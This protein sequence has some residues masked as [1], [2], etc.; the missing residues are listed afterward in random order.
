MFGIRSASRRPDH[1]GL[2]AFNQHQKLCMHSHAYTAAAYFSHTNDPF[3][4]RR[5]TLSHTHRCMHIYTAGH[6][7][8]FDTIFK[9]TATD[10]GKMSPLFFRAHGWGW[11]EYA[12][13]ECRDLLL[14]LYQLLEEEESRMRGVWVYG[15][16]Q[17]DSTVWDIGNFCRG[18]KTDIYYPLLTLFC[19][20]SH[21]EEGNA[22]SNE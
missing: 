5:W 2:T 18:T 8:P 7:V 13:N 17:E 14:Y 15:S 22:M 6:V 1:W 21:K 19:C 20:Y 9:L 11:L 3:L 4:S 12:L 10:E 16:F